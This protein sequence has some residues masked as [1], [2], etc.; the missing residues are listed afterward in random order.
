MS[1][2]NSVSE[3][4][5]EYRP[6]ASRKRN[7]AI[8]MV[9]RRVL[10]ADGTRLK[11]GSRRHSQPAEQAT[12][13]IFPNPCSICGHLSACLLS[14]GASSPR[15]HRLTPGIEA[16]HRL[17]SV[18]TEPVAEPLIRAERLGIRFVAEGPATLD[19][20]QFR[21]QA[22][23]F[24]SL[25]GPSGCGKSTLLRLIAGLRQATSG[26][27]L[28]SGL[29]PESARRSSSGRVAFVF[30][31][32]TLLPWRT[33]TDNIRLPL[34]LQGR[35][36]QEHPSLID[37]ALQLI[38]LTAADASKRPRMLSGGMR[39][40]VSLARALVTDPQL[41]LLDEPFA[42]LDDVLR[43]QLNEDLVRIW[44]QTRWTGIFVTHNVAE[45]VFL[46]QRVLVM[47]A[48]P[49]RIIADVPI[50]FAY[51]RTTEL[52]ADPDFG[53]LTVELTQKLREAVR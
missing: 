21:I 48:R 38:G 24:V 37:E 4:S 43:Q 16:D 42:A 51:P 20:V 45:A 10:A 11:H 8:L 40:R 5:S 14:Y 17:A 35:P 27:L 28:V 29:S 18:V 32:P 47:S 3:G 41:L 33:V 15:V 6:I 34:E 19:G 44:Q 50:P 13:R 30:Q 36:R 25:L 9:T 52:R 49:G 39:M 53:R 2:W 23:E 1:A 26:E 31:D 7:R 22:G 46:S 12:D